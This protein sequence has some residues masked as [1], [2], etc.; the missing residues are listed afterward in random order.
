MY[1]TDQGSYLVQGWRTDEPETVEIP[2][3]LLGFA[4]PDTFVGSTMAATG[5]GTFTLS[6]RPVTEPD[7]LAQLDLAEDET[8]IEVPKLERNFYGASAAR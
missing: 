7:T 6:G 4:E 1:A 8:A 2:H 3:L 5:R